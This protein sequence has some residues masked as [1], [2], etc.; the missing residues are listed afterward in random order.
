M[1][2]QQVWREKGS[3]DYAT[4]QEL[5]SDSTPAEPTTQ[6]DQIP[7]TV[8]SSLPLQFVGVMFDLEHGGMA[9]GESIA[10]PDMIQV[11]LTVS[12]CEIRKGKLK[13]E[14]LGKLSK[15]VHS[16]RNI[17]PYLQ[18]KLGIKPSW[19]PRSP[20]RHAPQLRAV[21]NDVGSLLQE[22]RDKAGSSLPVVFMAHN[23]FA[24]D[25]P[26][27]YWNLQRIGVD[28]YGWFKKIG[29]DRWLDTLEFARLV[30][31]EKKGNGV[32]ELYA[33]EVDSTG[34]GLTFHDALDDCVATWAVLESQRFEAGLS[35]A[36][37]LAKSVMSTEGLVLKIRATREKKA[38]QKAPATNGPRKR[39]ACSV[40]GKQGHNKGNKKKCPGPPKP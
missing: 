8:I 12:K 13:S 19:H 22:C 33:S 17:T 14:Q 38:A 25:A 9:K 34:G 30:R 39:G 4:G 32:Q 27:L 40:C 10:D 36:V 15:Y 31:G 11:G 21:I 1:R 6:T 29:I 2:K 18:N 37:W 16:R 5:D 26:V 7:A 3:T 20:L 35:N 24:C 28:A 23:G